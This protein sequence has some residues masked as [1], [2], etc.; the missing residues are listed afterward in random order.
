MARHFLEIKDYSSAE[1]Q[2]LLA[3]SKEMKKLYKSGGRDVCLAGKTMAM[4]FEKPSA[5]TRMSFETL[6]TQM[7]G[8]A[9]YIRQEDIGGLGQREPIKDLTRVLNGYVDVI[10]ART[11]AHESVLE[12]ARYATI[13]VINA[14]TDFSHPCQAM[15]DMLTIQEHCGSLAGRKLVYIGDSNNVAWSL[16]LASLRLGLQMIIASPAKYSFSADLVKQLEAQGGPGKVTHMTDPKAAA[17]GADVIYT[18]TWTSMGQEQEKQQRIK[19]FTGFQVNRG[20]MK[21]AGP[22]AKFMHCLPAY[23]D[24]ETTDEV[25]ESKQSIVFEQAE[26]RLHFQRALVKYLCVGES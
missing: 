17:E 26:N 20:L 6:M 1:L 9:M 22:Q 13:P 10:V 11:F 23:R 5:R 19:D 21:V 2:K 14:L 12:L 15:A 24:L 3:Q 4:I 16:A 7:G 25:I 18:D 8:S